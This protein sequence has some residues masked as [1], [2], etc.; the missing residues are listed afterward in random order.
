VRP[1]LI[2]AV[3][4]NYRYSKE[5]ESYVIDVDHLDSVEQVETPLCSAS[6]LK[7]FE[8]D[9]KSSRH[10][11]STPTNFSMSPTNMSLCRDDSSQIGFSIPSS[12]SFSRNGTQKSYG[13][14]FRRYPSNNA[15]EK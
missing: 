13:W 10:L 14:N 5:K 11:L 1:S 9:I 6:Q 4:Y 3:N 12:P 7:C 15:Q 8:E 2:I